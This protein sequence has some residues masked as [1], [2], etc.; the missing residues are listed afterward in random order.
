MKAFDVQAKQAVLGSMLL[1]QGQN[2][3]PA[4]IQNSS[5]MG[6]LYP[7]GSTIRQGKRTQMEGVPRGQG[8]QKSLNTGV[9]S[10]KGKWYR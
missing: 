10:P 1:K 3:S 5:Q 6:D 2:I 7:I 9:L 4:R 8:W